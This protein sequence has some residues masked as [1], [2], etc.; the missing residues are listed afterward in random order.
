MLIWD[1]KTRARIRV[2]SGHSDTVRGAAYSP[3]G[4]HIVTA[5]SDKTVRVWDAGSGKQLIVLSGHGDTVNSASWSPDGK[6][7]VTASDD[8]TARVWDAVT[9]AQIA[10]LTGHADKVLFA[11][12]SPDGRYIVT[13]SWDKTARIWDA[14]SG[15]PL[16]VLSGH[17]GIV[18]SASY[19]PD[20][21]HIVTGSQDNTARIWDV[22]GIP[23]LNAQIE[24]AEAAEFDPLAAEIRMEL[25]LSDS[26]MERIWPSNPAPCDL[27]AASSDDPDR[28]SPGVAFEL[29]DPQKALAA[30]AATKADGKSRFRFAY[31]RGRAYERKGDI[32]A[33]RSAYEDALSGGYRIAGANL[34][35]LLSDP[36][37]RMLDLKSAIRLYEKAWSEGVKVAALDLGALY[38]RG[39]L[40]PNSRTGYALA[41]DKSK[42]WDWYRNGA[43]AGEPWALSEFA[44][45][46][47]NAATAERTVDQK[48]VRL[49]QGFSYIAAA[50]ERAHADGWP[51]EVWKQWRYRRAALARLLA[52]QGM[53]QQVAEKFTAVRDK[54]GAHQPSMLEQMRSWLHL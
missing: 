51:D 5:S 10:L 35:N 31:Q 24:W 46:N 22:S 11:A 29:I 45:Y 52:A 6:R 18:N 16:A 42:A 3:D 50:C 44:E 34:A 2:L 41:P 48:K 9:G 28:V 43:E 21:K 4:T 23:S 32:A 54:W 7:I 39:V 40:A 38:M 1:V 20:G 13:A 47:V 26:S 14:A 12:Y 49:L 30:C 8:K 53:M 36:S 27:L 17:D 19:S 25:A 37:D 33:A 15:A